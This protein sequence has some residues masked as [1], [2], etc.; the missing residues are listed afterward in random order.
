MQNA[1]STVVGD[2]AGRPLSI[3][4]ADRLLP[5]LQKVQQRGLGS[6]VACCPSH[7]DSNPS[8]S[9][10]ETSDGNLGS[11]WSLPENLR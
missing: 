4:P 7:E 5:R 6:W 9:I 10:R 2:R 3:S 8:L 11:S 1:S